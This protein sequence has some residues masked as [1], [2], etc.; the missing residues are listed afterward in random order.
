MIAVK[1][2]NVTLDRRKNNINEGQTKQV[3]N[4]KDEETAVEAKQYIRTENRQELSTE[5][6]EKKTTIEHKCDTIEELT[7]KTGRKETTEQ[8]NMVETGKNGETTYAKKKKCFKCGSE[9]HLIR[10]CIE[11]NNLWKSYHRINPCH[12]CKKT[13]HKAME[14]WFKDQVDGER[15]CFRRRSPD[16]VVKFCSQPNK[17]SVSPA[18]TGKVPEIRREIQDRYKKHRAKED[19]AMRILLAA[20]W[21]VFSRKTLLKG[22]EDS[23]NQAQAWI[24]L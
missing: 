7:H 6:G 11:E 4:W 18:T 19:Q 22:E 24:H 21:C 13:G 12:I 20:F 2:K 8:T 16:H 17:T 15:R 14:C 23:E 9:N 10:Y 5:E 3:F 1:D